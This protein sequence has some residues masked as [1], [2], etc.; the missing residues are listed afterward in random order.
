[1]GY[2]DL[3]YLHTS[4]LTE[5]SDVYSFRVVLAELLTGQRAFS[6]DRLDCDRNLAMFFV[7][8][9]KDNRLLDL[10]D[11]QLVAEE[12]FEQLKLDKRGCIH[13]ENWMV[14]N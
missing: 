5:K 4:Q 7:S 10:F 14:V 1:M 12:N 2:L 9:I 8:S 13:G 3:E 6:F 11:S